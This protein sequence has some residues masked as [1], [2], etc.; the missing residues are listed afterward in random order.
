MR[1]VTRASGS[2]LVC[3]K[4]RSA[5]RRPV[6]SD[7]FDLVGFAAAIDMH[8]H[9]DVACNEAARWQVRHEYD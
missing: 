9:A 5:E 1:H 8:D 6:V 3:R 2:N 7:E 4:R